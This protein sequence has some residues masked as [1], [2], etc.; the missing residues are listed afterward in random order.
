VIPS[1]APSSR[2]AF[3]AALAAAGVAGCRAELPARPWRIA[4]NVF[5]GYEPLYLARELGYLRPERVRLIE[6]GATSDALRAFRNGS[7]EGAA[8]TL[9]E[10]L[11]LAAGGVDLRIVLQFDASNGADALVAHPSVPDLAGLRGRRVGVEAGALGA[12]MLS[13]TLAHAGLVPSDVIV[14]SLSVHE[15]EGPFLAGALDAVATFDPVRSRLIARGGRVL[16]DSRQLPGE[17]VDVLAVA[18]GPLQANPGPAFH[19]A[20]AWFRALDY[21]RSHEADACRRMA[22]RLRLTPEGVRQALQ[23]LALGGPAEN[24]AAVAPGGTLRRAADRL[25]RSM[26]EAR[27]LPRLVDAAALVDASIVERVRP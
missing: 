5:P 13:R 18:A 3:L 26:I 20:E 17:I 8:L 22:G 10:T 25:A 19:V 2:R 11:L 6:Y 9:D 7:I 14:V 1:P 23:L 12:Y 16:F 15:Q 4:T 21:L 24:R 27:L